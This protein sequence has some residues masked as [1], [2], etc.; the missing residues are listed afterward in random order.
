VCEYGDFALRKNDTMV[1]TAEIYLAQAIEKFI[2]SAYKS[3]SS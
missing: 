3:S 2:K 1:T